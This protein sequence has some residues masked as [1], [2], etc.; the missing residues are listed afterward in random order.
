MSK[1]AHT[2]EGA[3][4]R[5]RAV[6]EE[7]K[8]GDGWIRQRRTGTWVTR[9]GGLIISIATRG[10]SWLISYKGDGPTY[11]RRW[12]H[13]ELIEELE[14]AKSTA[15]EHAASIR[16]EIERERNEW[17]F[18]AVTPVPDVYHCDDR[19]LSIS[20]QNCRVALTED[21]TP[22]QRKLLMMMPRERVERLFWVKRNRRSKR[23]Q[24]AIQIILETLET[25]RLSTEEG[26]TAAFN[27]HLLELQ[28]EVS[29]Q[30]TPLECGETMGVPASLSSRREG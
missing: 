16:G 2:P 10:E 1:Q 20:R 11:E 30:Q 15:I 19:F 3:S 25:A 18:H 26:F 27:A 4:P 24:V 23:D 29:S 12:D 5:R 7:H 9:R 8:E 21:F 14:L 13:P 6:E 28:G 17:D 22:E